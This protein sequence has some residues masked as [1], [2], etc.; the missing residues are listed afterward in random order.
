[1]SQGR[2]KIPIPITNHLNRN[3][4]RTCYWKET[5]GSRDR[6]F[7]LE[8]IYHS[9]SVSLNPLLLHFGMNP[10]QNNQSALVGDRSRI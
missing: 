10:H 8:F 4:M 5:R 3:K 6:G 7:H 9:E 2:R 1:M